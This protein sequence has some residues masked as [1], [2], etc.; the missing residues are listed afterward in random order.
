M[1]TIHAVRPDEISHLPD[2]PAQQTRWSSDTRVIGLRSRVHTNA[3]YLT[4]GANELTAIPTH[5]PWTCSPIL[6]WVSHVARYRARVTTPHHN[7]ELGTFDAPSM[8]EAHL[9]ASARART[10]LEDDPDSA[11]EPEMDIHVELVDGA[12]PAGYA[13][14]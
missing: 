9:I 14:E 1:Y 13:D 4:S 8:A 5:R 7:F 3:R 10:K 12:D 2:W 11:T 6:I